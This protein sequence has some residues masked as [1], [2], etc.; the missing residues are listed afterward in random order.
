[1]SGATRMTG[2]TSARTVRP[3][4]RHWVCAIKQVEGDFMFK[5]VVWA[6]DGSD[7][8]DQ[9]LP[10]VKQFADEGA[11]LVV[12]HCEEFALGLRGG[13][14]PVHADENDLKAKIERQVE[15]LS[16]E[17]LDVA[18]QL[19]T[20]GAGGVAHNIADVALTERADLIL[21]GTRG[22]TPL[23][24]LLLGSVTQR[25][26]LIGTCPVFAVPAGVAATPNATVITEAAAT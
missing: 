12:V 26:L 21:V 1:M 10:Y 24:G 18:L 14:Y 5:R 13:G 4:A 23:G 8:A 6:T 17:G 15:A 11:A 19:V 25:L 9:A 2:A 22:H 3:T 20:S 16:H 7:S